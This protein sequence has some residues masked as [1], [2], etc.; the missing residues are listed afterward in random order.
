MLSLLVINQSRSIVM[1]SVPHPYL[2]TKIV[3]NEYLL[4][5]SLKMKHNTYSSITP[6]WDVCMILCSGPKSTFRSR[7]RDGIFYNESPDLP[8]WFVAT[9]CEPRMNTCMED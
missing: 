7:R 4:G 2:T 5:D 8:N 1:L 3:T 6:Y 9:I